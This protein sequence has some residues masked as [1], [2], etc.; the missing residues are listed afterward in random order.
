MIK[1]QVIDFG[2]RKAEKRL[3]KKYFGEDDREDHVAL[4]SWGAIY[5]GE[6]Y[7]D[8]FYE[9]SGAREM[10]EDRK[11]VRLFLSAPTIVSLC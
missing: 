1:L 4:T 8:G 9:D 3:L 6:Y 11:S 10:L 2:M 5:S 7:L